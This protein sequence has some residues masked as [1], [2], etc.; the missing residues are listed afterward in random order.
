MMH[1][2]SGH[3]DRSTK[4]EFIPKFKHICIYI[5][6]P[7]TITPEANHKKVVLESAIKFSIKITV[8]CV[9]PRLKFGK[10]VVRKK[11]EEA[12]RPKNVYEFHEF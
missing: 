1:I 12:C 2:Q 7:E 3:Q 4:I 6:I 11:L 10:N 8:F 5:V 9:N